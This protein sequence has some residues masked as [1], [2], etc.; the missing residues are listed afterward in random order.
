MMRDEIILDS[1]LRELSEIHQ[2]DEEEEAKKKQEDQAKKEEEE[3]TRKV[4]NAKH[5][6]C[7][8]QN[9]TNSLESLWH[10]HG[11]CHFLGTLIACVYSSLA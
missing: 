9:W 10:W 5:V 3:V 8:A 2:H 7:T 4:T 6:T 1:I 11:L